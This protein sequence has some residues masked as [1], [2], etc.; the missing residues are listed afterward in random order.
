ALAA[1]AP[2]RTGQ[3][4]RVGDRSGVH[5]DLVRPRPQQRVEIVDLAHTATY[6][7]GDEHGIGGAAH[8]VDHG[9]PATGTRRDVEEDQFVGTLGVVAGRQFHRVSGVAQAL[10]VHTLHHP[11]GVDVQARDDPYGQTHRTAANAS[12][13]VKA[14]A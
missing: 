7:Q 5:P 4:I 14:P 10:E 12:G 13:N 9:R 3:Q 2:R 11:A 8:D 6:G 1:E